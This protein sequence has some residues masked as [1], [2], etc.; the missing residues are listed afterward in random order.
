MSESSCVLAASSDKVAALHFICR[1][2]VVE[3]IGQ[4]P[5]SEV[6]RGDC[7]DLP[8]S[9]RERARLLKELGMSDVVARFEFAGIQGDLVFPPA[10]I[11]G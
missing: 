10:G 1:C 8:A 9:A 4:L 6:G 3:S 11:E 5:P 2:Q 7:A